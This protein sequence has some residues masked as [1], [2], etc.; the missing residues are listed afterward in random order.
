[1]TKRSI[2]SF[3]V[4][5]AALAA[6]GTAHAAAGV[7]T[8]RFVA[9][10]EGKQETTWNVPR[11]NSY[12]DCQGQ[13]WEQAKGSET[14]RFR[15]RPMR[16]LAYKMPLADVPQLRYGSWSMLGAQRADGLDGRGRIVRDGLHQ[17]GIEPSVCFDLTFPTVTDTGPYD[18][19]SRTF[20]PSVR[21]EW[22]NQDVWLQGDDLF[23]PIGGP[24]GYQ[25]CPV[26]E[27]EGADAGA[28]TEIGQRFPVEDLFDRRQG[29]V[30]VLGRKSWTSDVASGRG[31]G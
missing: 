19:G 8:A 30:I 14:V 29:L 4:A 17:R 24:K 7:Q 23:V 22:R 15:T 5:A 3:A 9:S 31:T 18:C 6:A 2:T 25:N 28:F 16:L 27:A 26:M 12:R 21:L 11:W 1:M 20:E 10:V 13:R